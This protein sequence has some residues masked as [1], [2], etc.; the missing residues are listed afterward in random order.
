MLHRVSIC[1][2]C[3]K[4]FSK[5]SATQKYC[6]NPC[7]KSLKSEEREMN[8]RSWHATM[9]LRARLWK[10]ARTDPTEV[11]RINKEMKKTEGKEFT[12]MVFGD[13][14]K[15]KEFKNLLK[16]YKEYKGGVA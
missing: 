15:K 11:L 6:H 7:T 9:S 2:R 1:P 13:I 12:E 14:L 5:E 4:T 3:K 10:L 8:A 16:T